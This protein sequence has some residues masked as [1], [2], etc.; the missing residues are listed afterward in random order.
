LTSRIT[1]DQGLVVPVRIQ[2]V[3]AVRSPSRWIGQRVLRQVCEEAQ[4]LSHPPELRVLL[5][6]CIQQVLLDHG[7]DRIPS[8]VCWVV[9]G[10]LR[11]Q[12][13]CD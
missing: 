3:P 7:A 1:E 10:D 11:T 5:S 2:E 4:S 13:L 12:R 8:G 6:L 9:D